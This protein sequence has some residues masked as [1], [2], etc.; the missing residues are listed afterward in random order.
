MNITLYTHNKM[1]NH[2]YKYIYIYIYIYIY[3]YIYTHDVYVL[4]PT[5]VALP[6]GCLPGC[7]PCC[8]APC[9][10]L[11][12]GIA[13]L[14]SDFRRSG[15]TVL[16]TPLSFIA[17]Y[18][19]RLLLHSLAIIINHAI[20][21]FIIITNIIVTITIAVLASTCLTAPVPVCFL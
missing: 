8:Q 17:Y 2:T 16:C 6:P 12:H 18:V 13:P 10:L 20:I 5:Y 15:S 4:Y 7:P 19:T 1:N 11:I 9:F 21:S 14:S 3:T